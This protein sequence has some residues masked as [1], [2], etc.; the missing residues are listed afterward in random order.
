MRASLSLMR[1]LLALH[2]AE[3]DYD[4]AFGCLL[5]MNKQMTRVHVA[6]RC[7]PPEVGTII[8][9]ATIT[10]RSYPLMV[11]CPIVSRRLHQ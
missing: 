1:A 4:G 3:S 2:L 8:V 9:D 10:S 6:S 11:F 7:C 5:R